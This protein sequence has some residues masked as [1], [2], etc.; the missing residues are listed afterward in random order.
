MSKDAAPGTA[1]D[2]WTTFATSKASRPSRV[3]AAAVVTGALLALVAASAGAAGRKEPPSKVEEQAVA[4]I[5]DALR[6]SDCALVA[7]RLND[8]LK[9]KYPS[10]Y[11]L[12]GTLYE[13]GV[14]LKPDCERAARQTFKR[15]LDLRHQIG[16]TEPRVRPFFTWL[17]DDEGV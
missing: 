3:S 12:A 8:G 9:R 11:L 17:H 1:L 6:A 10:V 16:L 14:C 7:S 4:G 5:H 13:Q 2:A 15:L